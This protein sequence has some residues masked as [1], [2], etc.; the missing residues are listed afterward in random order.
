M[1]CSIESF[2]SERAIWVIWVV[3]IFTLNVFN[4]DKKRG[5]K[6][7]A[8]AYTSKNQQSET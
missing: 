2:W 3:D 1:P 7:M 4:M 5:K 8:C 6:Q